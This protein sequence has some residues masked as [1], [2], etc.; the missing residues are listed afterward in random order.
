MVHVCHN[1]VAFVQNETE[2]AV[3]HHYVIV[4]LWCPCGQQGLGFIATALQLV[5]QV[6]SRNTSTPPSMTTLR[7]LTL[8][9]SD[10]KQL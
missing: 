9:S 2:P 6:Q 10:F 3:I 4:S 5:V 1:M 8:F 7:A